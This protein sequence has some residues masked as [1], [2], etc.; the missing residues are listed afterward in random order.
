MK[1][2]KRSFFQRAFNDERGQVLIWVAVGMVAMFG[3]AG[4]TIDVGHAYTVRNLLQNVT[5]AA[6][7]A[8]A[9]NVYN[10]QS[11]TDATTAANLY[12]GYNANPGLVQ[13]T[14]YPKV[15]TPC[16]NIL[17]QGDTGCTN[18]ANGN[19]VSPSVANAMRL[20]TQ[21][22]VKTYF[23]AI[24]GIPS[25]TVQAT[26]Q[27]SM[28]GKALPW[29]VA[30]I[31][32]A[33]G[34]MGNT[35]TNC[36]SLTQEQCAM[37]GVQTLLSTI[38]PCPSGLT[39]CTPDQAILRVALFSFPGVST[40]TVA[41]D[42]SGGTPNFM[43]YSLPLVP[44]APPSTTT[45]YTPLTYT[46]T[47]TTGTGKNKKT[48]T[49]TWTAT[50]LVTYNA[51]GAASTNPDKN[52]FE[53]DFYQPN[54]TTGGLNPSSLLVKALGYTGTSKKTGYLKPMSTFGS[55]GTGIMGSGGGTGITY[56]ASVIYAAQT[57]LVAEQTLY[58]QTQNAIIFLSDGQANLSAT[59]FP[60]GTSPVSTIP[61]TQGFQALTGNG[62]YPDDSDEC[63][64][65]IIAAQNATNAG[66]A[67]FS[68]AY[69]SEDTGCGVSGGGGT[70]TTTLPLV[71]YPLG[72]LNVSFSYKTLTPCI[73]MENIASPPTVANQVTTSYFY[74]DYLQ[75]GTKGSACQ[76][77]SH[78]ITSM[79]DI[80]K[81]I[82]THFQTAALLPNNA[83]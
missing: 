9:G 29:N 25:L 37:T 26:T 48:T 41:D 69:G 21:V 11:I 2:M 6:G 10:N 45:S 20:T 59:D 7:L 73:T 18:D 71:D 81:S 62:L 51:S 17:M 65:A 14:G 77:D 72:S 30:I 68:V 61:A 64:Q 76:D 8:A 28:L 36:S 44:P 34:S 39:T 31:L 13:N 43:V 23:M 56:Y 82:R 74:S 80:F 53:S 4:L 42:T 83:T 22:S 47:T 5:N 15:S 63:Q 60:S 3:V 38:N 78:P 49:N 35:D 16:L 24:F 46:E 57:A 55:S 52:G 40:S 19:A 58:P 66:T 32:D 54:A 27:A 70:D 50:Y 67:V 75:S 79:N 33:T 12:L 1:T